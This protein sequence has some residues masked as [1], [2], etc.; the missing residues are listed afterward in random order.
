[1]YA[2]TWVLCWSVCELLHVWY[3]LVEIEIFGFFVLVLFWLIM[4]D[5]LKCFWSPDGCDQ[6]F[7]GVG[8]EHYLIYSLNNIDWSLWALSGCPQNIS[9]YSVGHRGGIFPCDVVVDILHM[10]LIPWWVLSIFLV[11]MGC[12]HL[13]ILF[14]EWPWLIVVSAW[15]LASRYWCLVRRTYRRNIYLRCCRWQ[16][17]FI[18]FI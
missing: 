12:E 3:Y 5:I 11:G 7:G 8:C 6:D 4:S 17:L 16:T 10:L 2:C 13:L 14:I 15:W 1:M 18:V 9:I